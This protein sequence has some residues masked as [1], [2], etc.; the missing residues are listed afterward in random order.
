MYRPPNSK[1]C[2]PAILDHKH[3]YLLGVNNADVRAPRSQHLAVFYQILIGVVRSV[4]P[5]PYV[6]AKDAV[7]KRAQ[8][9][10]HNY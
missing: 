9:V 10:A 8:N 7:R 2:L 5:I 6:S 3:Q 1:D 4:I